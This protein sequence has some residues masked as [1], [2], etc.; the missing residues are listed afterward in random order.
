M[1]LT[2]KIIASGT[3]SRIPNWN[4]SSSTVLELMNRFVL[5]PEVPTMGGLDDPQSKLQL[6]D[7]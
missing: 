3:P 4:S 7:L 1:L 6:N 2:N 5:Q